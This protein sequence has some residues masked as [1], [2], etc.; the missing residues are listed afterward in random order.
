MEE[1]C[2]EYI[3]PELIK[4][5]LSNLTQ[6][7]F[8]VTDAC[9]LRCKYCGFGEFYD[10]YE[11]REDK[12]LSIEKAK[13]IIDYLV[14]LW[15]SH[16]NASANRNV[17]ISFYGGEPLLNM[18]FIKAIVK[19]IEAIDCKHRFF[20]FSMTTNAMLLSKYM[21]YLVEKKFNLLISLDGNEKNTSYRVDH[22]QKP[23]FERIIKNV[24]KLKMAYPDYFETKVNF[25][26]VLH[27][28]NS[29]EDI[30]RFFK[31]KYHKH[32]SIGEVNSMGIKPEKQSL[33]DQMYRNSTESLH[34]SEHYKEIEK[35]M[36]I[37]TASFQSVCTF[38]H[39]YSGF[40][41]QDYTDLLFDKTKVKKI[42]TGTCLP[43]S[44]K[45]YVTV[46][47]KLKPCERIGHQ[48]ALGEVTETEVILNFEAI[49]T[50]YNSYFAKM[51]KQCNN[52]HNTK[53]CTQC[54]FYLNDLEHNPICEGFMAQTDFK[55]YYLNQLAFLAN[56]PE[57][58]YR[59]MEEIIVE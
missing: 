6:L 45:M 34:Q 8:E 56:N 18:S 35:E 20:T 53:A 23:A 46:N 15:N 51:E 22:N 43:F 12:N 50:K 7:T 11:K 13:H 54:I 27:N 33:F 14:S 3:N 58:Y 37:H 47:G 52:C 28:R 24:D 40:V 4:F 29:V 59:I 55:T 49:S 5:Q 1:T 38:I 41:F 36:F 26:S 44:K 31:E 10:N 21:D 25:N 16:R 48:F 30:F 9:N 2:R 19:H 42:P 57:D 17:Y 39:Q 32:P